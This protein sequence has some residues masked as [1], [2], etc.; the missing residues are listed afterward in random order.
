MVLYG[1][2]F[3]ILASGTA[4][5]LTFILYMAPACNGRERILTIAEF[6]LCMRL[7]WSV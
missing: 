5:L 4:V 2:E 7:A 3:S 1:S 6:S